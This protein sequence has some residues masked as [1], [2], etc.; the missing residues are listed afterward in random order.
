MIWTAS[1]RPATKTALIRAALPLLK[2]VAHVLAVGCGVHAERDSAYR[3]LDLNGN[4]VWA[5]PRIR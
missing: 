4:T 2:K 3:G 5:K 1:A